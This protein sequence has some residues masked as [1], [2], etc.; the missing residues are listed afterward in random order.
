M[1]E[2]RDGSARGKSAIPQ[3]RAPPRLHPRDIAPA[4]IK[5]KVSIPVFLDTLG[6]RSPTP[7]LTFIPS[8]SLIHFP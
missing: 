5:L 3:R 2:E 7:F 6:K 1:G 8:P 4:L